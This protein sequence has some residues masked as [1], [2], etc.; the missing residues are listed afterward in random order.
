MNQASSRRAPWAGQVLLSA[1]L[2]LAMAVA[3]AGMARAQNGPPPGGGARQGPPQEAIE[4]CV[5]LAEQDPCPMV[6]P[7]GESI[8]GTCVTTP[9]EDLVCMPADAPPM[10]AD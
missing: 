6:T 9:K 10:P 1:G 2:S 5:G 4:A 8:T 7:D 3:G